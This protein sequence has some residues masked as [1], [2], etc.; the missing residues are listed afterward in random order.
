[1]IFPTK[2]KSFRWKYIRTA[3]C[4]QDFQTECPYQEQLMKS[5]SNLSIGYY[6]T[7]TPFRIAWLC[8]LV[9]MVSTGCIIPSPKAPATAPHTNSF[10]TSIPWYSKISS[11]HKFKKNKIKLYLICFVIIV[12]L[13]LASEMRHK[14]DIAGQ[15]LHN[16]KR[17]C[18]TK[19][20]AQN[21][22]LGCNCKT[23]RESIFFK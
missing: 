18:V 9:L 7:L 10:H 13:R 21:Y 16:A 22:L 4:T 2:E 23:S 19:I 11:N 14:K 1:M 12:R 3:T 6:N 15:A 17:Y 20:K 8:I 5:Q